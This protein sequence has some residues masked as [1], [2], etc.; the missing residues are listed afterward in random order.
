[1]HNEKICELIDSLGGCTRALKSHIKSDGT[2][3]MDIT[4]M[5][6]LC[7]EIKCDVNQLDAIL[8]NMRKEEE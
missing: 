1:M 3:D 2:F 7:L 5:R 8:E 4:K 6:I